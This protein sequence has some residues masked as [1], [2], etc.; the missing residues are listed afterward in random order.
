MRPGFHVA[1]MIMRL[2]TG[3]SPIAS[4]DLP[5]RIVRNVHRHIAVGTDGRGHRQAGKWLRASN[6]LVLSGPARDEMRAAIHLR[7][8]LVDVT[9]IEGREDLVAVLVGQ[10]T[11]A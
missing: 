5:R 9:R 8:R 11:G 7:L 1:G 3:R 4:L 2:A 10:N 6:P